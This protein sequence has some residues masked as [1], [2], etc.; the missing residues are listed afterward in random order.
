MSFNKGMKI[1][2]CALKLSLKMNIK[3]IVLVFALGITIFSCNDDTN[4]VT[5][6]DHAAQAIIDDDS[7]V[8]YLATHYFNTTLDSIKK[9][10]NGQTPFSSDVQ[11]VTVVE[12]DGITYKLYYIVSEEGVGYQPTKIDNILPTYK[13]ELLDGTVFDQRETIII[14]NPWLNLLSTIRG[15]QYGMPMFKGGNNISMSGEPLEFENFGKGFLF[16]P[17][18]LAYLNIGS[19]LIPP[20]TPIV[21]K[22]DLQ[23]ATA[24]DHDVDGVVSNDEDINNDGDVTNDDTDEDSI[25]NY[26]DI[27]DDGDGIQTKNEDTND[28]GDPRN[29]DDDLDGTPNYLDSDS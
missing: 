4:T 11:S 15:W 14:G 2:S 10:D 18:G 20:N 26:V 7:L 21:F 6:F 1:V 8:N 12:N 25:P 19:G 29:D 9:V 24:A 28:D 23:Y 5:P 22:I 27:D 16:I 13:G 3:N 17:S